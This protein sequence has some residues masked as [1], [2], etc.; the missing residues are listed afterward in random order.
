MNSSDGIDCCCNL[1]FFK[2]SIIE[3]WGFST[4]PWQTGDIVDNFHLIIQISIRNWLGLAKYRSPCPTHIPLSHIPSGSF[5]H[6]TTHQTTHH[7][8]HTLKPILSSAFLVWY[9]ILTPTCRTTRITRTRCET[10]IAP[11]EDYKSHS[12]P[13]FSLITRAWYWRR[14]C[15]QAQ[16]QVGVK[17][18]IP[19]FSKY[20]FPSIWGW[21]WA[22]PKP[23]P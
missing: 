13:L 12:T 5:F 23:W 22:C 2:L 4:F 1:M 16:C 3:H 18:V 14:Q 17:F 6:P 10:N 9:H 7:S 15:R 21:D 19:S 8:K 11:L 20:L